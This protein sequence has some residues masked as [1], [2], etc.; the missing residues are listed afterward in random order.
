MFPIII[1]TEIAVS[2]FL[3]AL[4]VIWPE[5]FLFC[6]LYVFIYFSA[7]FHAAHHALDKDRDHAP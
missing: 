2:K 1:I 6:P 5:T 4:E 7:S 3:H